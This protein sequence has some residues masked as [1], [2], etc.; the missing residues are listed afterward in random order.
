[1]LDRWIL[2]RGAELEYRMHEHMQ[3]YKLAEVAP[4]IIGF[5]DDLTN[6]YI[7][8]NRER[9]WSH[10]D[11]TTAKDKG[12]AY[13][14]LWTSLK[15][16]S[17]VIAPYLPYLADVLSLALGGQSVHDLSN[18]HHSVHEE[19]FS[20]AGL[21]VP[22]AA[23][24][25]LLE[26]VKL[27]KSVILLGRALRGEA[28]IGLRQP[29]QKLRVAGLSAA[30]QKILKPM[31]ELILS[32]LNVKELEM[33][34]KASDL[35]E[36]S[37]KPNHRV[38]GKK[39]GGA[40]KE[41][42]N[43]LATWTSV[44]IAE[45]EKNKKVVLKGFELGTDDIQIVRKAKEGKL[46]QAGYGVVAE[47]DTALTDALIREGLS[48]EV[49]NRIQQ[50]RKEKKLHL[51]DRIAIRCFVTKGSLLENVLHDANLNKMICGETLAENIQFVTSADGL[52]IAESFE[53]HGYLSFDIAKA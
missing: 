37:A 14:T 3:A 33:V 53:A 45:F 30:Q 12:A 44:E 2:A 47:L 5:I 49:I 42:Q 38:L 19:E 24:H 27:A 50:L 35:V 32:E 1:V 46:A 7:R 11:A 28:K 34:A 20:T 9:F 18:V 4:E 23:T 41:I 15:T 39:V 10:A 48:R 21:K 29:L 43:L 22:D 13:A 26:E 51:A 52:S 17:M 16:L 6:W 25:L 40:M 36:E 8:L 31:F